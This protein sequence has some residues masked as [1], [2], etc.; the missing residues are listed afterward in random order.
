TGVQTCALPIYVARWRAA[1]R[2]LGERLR[3]VSGHRVDVRQ[4]AVHLLMDEEVIGLERSIALLPRDEHAR[5]ALEDRL[6]DVADL[7]RAREGREHEGRKPE[8]PL[9]AAKG[10]EAAVGRLEGE[11][12]LIADVDVVL[13]RRANLGSELADLA[14]VL[15]DLDV[16]R[17]EDH[18]L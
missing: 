18:V 9:L 6:V 12:P 3:H 16:G 11:L 7:P 13:G 5:R 4:A 17:E 15:E 10:R 1:F 14:E 2:V 8:A